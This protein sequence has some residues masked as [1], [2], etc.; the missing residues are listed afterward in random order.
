MSIWM[1]PS[2]IA[3]VHGQRLLKERK[4]DLAAVEEGHV[5]RV[6][7]RKAGRCLGSFV[8]RNLGQTQDA[9]VRM[10]PKG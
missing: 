8:R 9:F 6:A 4:L 5:K 10:L 7:D 3:S 1:R 2:R